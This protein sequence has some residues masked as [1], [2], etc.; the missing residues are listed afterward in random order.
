MSSVADIEIYIGPAQNWVLEKGNK[1]VFLQAT[2]AGVDGLDLGLAKRKGVIVASVKGVNSYY[3]AEMALGLML[4]LTKRIVAFDR[5]AKKGVFP[6]YSWEYSSGSLKGKTVIILGYGGI[7]RELARMLKPLG[8]RVIGVRRGSG[9]S[10]GYADLVISVS[11]LEK[12][13]GE[14]DFLVIAAPLTKETRGLVNKE[15]LSKMKRG[16]YII[17]VGRGAIVDEEALYEALSKGVLAG[18]ALDV[19]WLYP[20]RDHGKSYSSKGIHMLENVIATPHRA[21]FVEDA[22]KDIAMFIVENVKRFIRGEP[23]EGLV[24]LDKGY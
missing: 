6:P 3:V 13:I 20:G 4:S 19:W 8:V 14:G 21:G 5:M 17:N 11:E 23:V 12:Y 22:E 9:G 18:A 24:D 7:G 10:D 15:L 16:S 2:H 1:L